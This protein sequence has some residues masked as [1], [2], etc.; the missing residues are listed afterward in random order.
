MATVFENQAELLRLNA[1]TSPAVRTLILWVWRISGLLI[2]LL[3]ASF[4]SWG[5]PMVIKPWEVPLLSL[6]SVGAYVL[7]CFFA[8]HLSRYDSQLSAYLWIAASTFSIFAFVFAF[9]L[10]SRGYY[11]RT[12]LITVLL[13]TLVWVLGGRLIQQRMLH[14]TFAF[15]PGQVP[16][17]IR[18]QGGADWIC[19][20]QPELPNARLDGLV[21]DFECADPD[22]QRLIAACAIR[23]VPIIHGATLHESFSGR[24]DLEWLSHGHAS[25]F[26][27]H[28]MYAPVKRVMDVVLVL[29]SLP[30]VLPLMLF[31]ALFIKLESPGPSLFIQPR[32]GQA[33]RLFDMVKFRS[34]CVNAD[35]HGAQFADEDD[36]RVTRVGR[37]IRRFRI[38][39]LPQ[40]WN[41]LKGEMSLIGPRPEQVDFVRQF[42]QSIPFYTYRHLVKPGLT[43]WA[44]VSQGYA[45]CEASTREKLE[46]DLYYAKHCSLWLDLIIIF[47]TLRIMLTGF[48]AR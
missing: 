29:V 28:P 26:H 5:W 16:H 4:L 13:V 27:P 39:E 35:G 9:L 6:A 40:F 10:F 21:A 23:G 11:S 42:E 15:M 30:V 3:L 34:M 19:L 14:P 7:S 45:A 8:H 46:Y 12:F 31:T 47:R 1:K 37:V 43:G 38:D 41:V 25:D 24:V 32:V 48:G 18:S 20:N 44:Q 33:G 22:W 17:E 36:P 2:A